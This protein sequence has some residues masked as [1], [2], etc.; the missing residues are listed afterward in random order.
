MNWGSIRLFRES[1]VMG[2]KHLD[3]LVVSPLNDGLLILHSYDQS[4]YW[5]ASKMTMELTYGVLAGFLVVIFLCVRLL[6]S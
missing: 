2:S 1:F 3:Q 6:F 4:C 5:S